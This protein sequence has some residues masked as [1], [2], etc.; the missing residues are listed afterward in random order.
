MKRTVVK[1]GGSNLKS[2]DDINN[3][4]WMGDDYVH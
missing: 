4:V 1:F 3:I 2:A